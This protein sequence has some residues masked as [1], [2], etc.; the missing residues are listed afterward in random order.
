[1]KRITIVKI[2]LH[3]NF[4]TTIL[5]FSIHKARDYRPSVTRSKRIYFYFSSLKL[6]SVFFYFFWFRSWFTRKFRRLC[7]F[8]TFVQPF[9]TTAN[10]SRQKL[11]KNYNWWCDEMSIVLA[12]MLR[13]LRLIKD[14]RK[15][16]LFVE[17]R[18]CIRNVSV[19]EGIHS[20]ENNGISC[21]PNL[22]FTQTVDSAPKIF[23]QWKEH[24]SDHISFIFLF[25]KIIRNRSMASGKCRPNFVDLKCNE[26]NS[27]ERFTRI[28]IWKL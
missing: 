26:M 3:V 10:E 25:S 4:I 15:K 19:N 5:F 14:R 9:G 18:K 27:N 1:M 6:L 8:E 24:W 12:F 13:S 23:A 20:N 21:C 17:P 28:L 7:K 16:K 2:C 22:D 11:T